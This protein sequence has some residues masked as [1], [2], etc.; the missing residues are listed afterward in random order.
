MKALLEHG[1]SEN[2]ERTES[3]CL[4]EDRLDGRDQDD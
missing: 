3:I 1:K 4:S 2:Q